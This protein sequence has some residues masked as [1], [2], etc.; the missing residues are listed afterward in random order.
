MYVCMLSD[1]LAVV[2]RRPR[3][4]EY[5][6]TAAINAAGADSRDD[7]EMMRISHH[8]HHHQP[9]RPPR[10]YAD[11]EQVDDELINFHFKILISRLI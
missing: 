5:H 3:S 4:D 7:E 11:Y 2:G 8:H 9:A 6:P 1:K 10:H